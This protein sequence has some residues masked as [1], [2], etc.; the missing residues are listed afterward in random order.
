MFHGFMEHLKL[1]FNTGKIFYFFNS[2]FFK[3]PLEFLVA[4]NG[5]KL[6]LDKENAKETIKQI[7]EITETFILNGSDRELNLDAITRKNYLNLWN[8]QIGNDTKWV[9]EEQPIE[10]FENIQRVMTLELKMDVFPR[11]VR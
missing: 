5:L 3:E 11:F 10:L 6:I 4:L 9:L 7:K 2:F 8:K 1:E